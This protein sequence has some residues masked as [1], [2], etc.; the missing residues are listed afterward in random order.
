MALTSVGW[1]LTVQF[2]DKGENSTTMLFDLTAADETEADTDIATILAAYAAV[3]SLLVTGYHKSEVFEETGTLVIPTAADA[4]SEVDA[5]I[6]VYIAGAG[7]KKATVRIP[8]PT[9]ANVMVSTSGKNA[10]I[11]DMGAAGVIAWLGLFQTGGVATVS[12]GETAG[13]GI[14]GIRVTKAKRGG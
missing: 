14:E 5:K 7:S 9:A 6:S 3:G 1:R 2:L 11:V 12:D 13:L 10:N 8:G 4:Q